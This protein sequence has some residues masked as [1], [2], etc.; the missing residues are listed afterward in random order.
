MAGGRTWSRAALALVAAGGVLSAG[1]AATRRPPWWDGLASPWALMPAATPAVPALGQVTLEALPR[2]AAASAVVLRDG[3]R[4]AAFAGGPVTVLV[5][6][7]DVL[8]VDDPRRPIWIR[9]LAASRVALPWRARWVGPGRVRL[10]VVRAPTGRVPRS[11][12]DGT[13]S[14]ASVLG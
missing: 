8:A 2:A 14:G 11:D 10:G 5:A 3:L 12:N 13:I 7:G 6:P 9:V 1:I 4:V